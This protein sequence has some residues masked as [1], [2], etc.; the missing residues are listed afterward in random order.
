MY[1]KKALQAF[2][3]ITRRYGTMSAR[4]GSFA[5]FTDVAVFDANIVR[6]FIALKLELLRAFQ[7]ERAPAPADS[8]MQA[9]RFSPIATVL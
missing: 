3:P 1:V 6:Y 2:N 7:P 5:H 8:P 4:Y 9:S